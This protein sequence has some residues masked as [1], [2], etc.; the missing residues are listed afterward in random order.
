MPLLGSAPFGSAIFAGALLE[1]QVVSRQL[2]NRSI[3]SIVHLK[4]SIRRTIYTLK[5]RYGFPIDIYR[6][7]APV[8]DVTTG[9]TTVQRRKI[10]IRRMIVFPGLEHRDF[11]YTI[12]FIKAQSNFVSG[13]DVPITDRQF[14]IDGHD[15]P[16]DFAPRVGDYL[17]WQHQRYDIKSTTALD[18]DTGFF[19][20]GRKVNQNITYEIHEYTIRHQLK[21][22]SV[23]EYAP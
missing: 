19:I 8:Y 10:R 6:D 3:G 20:N 12:A 14:I 13:G 15:L 18:A 5:W 1:Q 22:G 11:F 2:R 9:L 4:K 17:I 21:V 16:K 7:L 23:F